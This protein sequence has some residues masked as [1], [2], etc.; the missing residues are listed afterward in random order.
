M[1]LVDISS[2]QLSSGT[3]TLPCLSRIIGGVNMQSD[4]T[5]A[6]VVTLQAGSST[7]PTV[8]E[9]SVKGP[10]FP[11]APII[12][13]N[14]PGNAST[15]VYVTITGT[16]AGVQIFEWRTADLAGEAGYST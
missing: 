15:G 5:N 1:Y 6:C 7:G 8:F 4:G 10:F 3:Y 12:N 11:V 16:N 9:Q 2:G 14:T 13:G